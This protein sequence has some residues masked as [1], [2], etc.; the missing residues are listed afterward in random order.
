MGWRT[1][2]AMTLST[3]DFMLS[4]PKFRRGWKRPGWIWS[5]LSRSSPL[6]P[7]SGIALS[8]PRSADR[9][10]PRPRRLAGSLMPRPRSRRQRPLAAQHLARQM[11]IGLGARAVEIVEQ[12]R[13]AVRR[14]LGDAHV[15]RDHGLVN[16]G[17]E[18][19]AHIGRDHVG[20]VVALVEHGQHH[21]LDFE[22]RIEAVLDPLD[23]V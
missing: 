17:A 13:L 9:P 7:G 12:H 22:A 4:S 19:L 15:A 21:A 1:P 23:G 10:R 14:R 20:Q 6:D 18:M 2:W 16:L 3:R 11:D 5:I 8:S